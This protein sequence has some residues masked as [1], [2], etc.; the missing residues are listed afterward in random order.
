[1]LVVH[2]SL[3]CG[4]IGDDKEISRLGMGN[5]QGGLDGVYLSTVPDQV[6]STSEARDV[7]YQYCCWFSNPT[8]SVCTSNLIDFI[9]MLFVVPSSWHPW[10]H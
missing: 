1:V 10:R 4:A 9:D 8:E 3:F 7:Q 2:L 5:A 6:V